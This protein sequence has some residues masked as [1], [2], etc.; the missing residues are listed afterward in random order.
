MSKYFCTFAG[1]SIIYIV[2]ETLML[3]IDRI[4]YIIAM[5]LCFEG[6]AIFQLMTGEGSY[7]IVMDKFQT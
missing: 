1:N 6:S 3:K 5:V 7:N 2:D 4:L